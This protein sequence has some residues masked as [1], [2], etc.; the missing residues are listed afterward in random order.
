MTPVPVELQNTPLPV[1][2]TIFIQNVTL[3]F[4]TL[5]VCSGVV[6]AGM[7]TLPP[8]TVNADLPL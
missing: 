4:D 3:P 7:V 5:K 8:F 6:E 1:A 2:L